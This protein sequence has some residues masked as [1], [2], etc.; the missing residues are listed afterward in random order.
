MTE[1]ESYF[2]PLLLSEL[3]KHLLLGAFLDSHVKTAWL[4]APLGCSLPLDL[5]LTLDT[6]FILPIACVSQ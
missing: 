3:R 1:K 2:L 6:A 5:L 4:A